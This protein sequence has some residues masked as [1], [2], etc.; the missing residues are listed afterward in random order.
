MSLGAPEII[1]I[2]VLAL[3][4]FGSRKLP[5]LGSSVGKTITSFKRGLA[6]AR[7]E[8]EALQVE[9]SSDS[10]AEA[11]TDRTADQS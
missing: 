1:G 10:T 7:E 5:E 3:L 8:D 6:D 4:L 2:I 11:E 9:A